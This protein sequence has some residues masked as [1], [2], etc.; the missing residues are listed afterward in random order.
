MKKDI[1]KSIATTIGDKTA[2]L[3][4]TVKAHSPEILLVAGI[5]SIVGGTIFACKATLKAEDIVM[6]AEEKLGMIQDAKETASPEDYTKDDILKDTAVVYSQTAGKFLKLYGGP[7]LAIA[8]G[9]GCVVASHNIQSSRINALSA[10]YF[11]L[12]Q[13]FRSYRTRVRER[14][15]DTDEVKLLEGCTTEEVTE[16]KQLKNGKE[17]EI[18][19]KVDIYNPENISV[20]ARFFDEGCRQWTKNPEYNLQYLRQAEAIMNQKLQTRGHVFLN[21]VYD[22]LGIPRT[23]AGNV[24]GWIKDGDDG[25]IDFGIY[26]P[27]NEAAHD[28]VNGWNRSILLDFNVDGVIID[29]IGLLKA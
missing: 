2:P 26:S 13:A 29:R 19:K 20:Y 6:E 10:A 8:G 12:D 17:K 7:V 5:A 22:L 27:V 4:A 1:F 23:Q 28:F 9:I 14:V 15:G 24:V 25:Y 3:T 18:V 16:I 11:G 21:E